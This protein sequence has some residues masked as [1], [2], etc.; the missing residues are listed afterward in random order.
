MAKVA[1]PPGAWS[2]LK[3]SAK[4]RAWHEARS[5]RSQLSADNDARK[6]R[7]LLERIELNPETVVQMASKNPD[8]LRE[9]LVRSAARLKK[10]GKL[11]STIVKSLG[12]LRNYLAYRHVSFD[13]YPKLEPIQAASLS[14]ERV[15]A[16]EE[17]GGILER[18]TLR[19]RAIALLMAHSGL[20]PATIAGYS[21]DRGLTLG[22]L[23]DLELS[24]EPKFKELPFAIRVPG[25]LSKTRASYISFGTRQLAIVLLSSLLERREGGEKLSPASPSSRTPRPGRSEARRDGRHSMARTGL[26]GPARSRK[27]SAKPYTPRCPKA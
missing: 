9:I 22:D 17:L 4:V 14:L 20:R 19:G 10:A 27:N 3:E 18:L 25:G 5:L 13:G 21:G 26:C 16:P 8:R 6:L 11:D 2:I 7:L 23:P 15:P 24:P 12:G 1:R